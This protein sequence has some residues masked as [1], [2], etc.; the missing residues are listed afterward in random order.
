MTKAE[1]KEI[2]K[3]ELKTALNFY[4]VDDVQLDIMTD[5][6]KAA[7]WAEYEKLKAKLIKTIG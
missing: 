3:S 5:A 6:D 7:F 1:I 2:V 4:E